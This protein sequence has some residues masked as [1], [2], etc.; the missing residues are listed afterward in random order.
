MKMYVHEHG[1]IL[2]GK[3]WEIRAKLK[4]CSE[5]YYYLNQ[6]LAKSSTVCDDKKG[7]VIPFRNMQ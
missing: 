6:Y 7:N 3:A 1:M 2:V 5:Q 4:E